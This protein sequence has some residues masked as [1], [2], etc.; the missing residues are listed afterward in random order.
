LVG[1]FGDI[2]AA[3]LLS[4][5]LPEI[6]VQSA[7]EGPNGFLRYRVEVPLN[8]VDDTLFHTDA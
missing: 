8:N 1:Y 2:E 6:P 5:E 4:G 3:K 7:I